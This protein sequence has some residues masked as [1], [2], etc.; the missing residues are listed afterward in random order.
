MIWKRKFRSNKVVRLECLKCLKST[1]N[2]IVILPLRK[3]VNLILLNPR[4]LTEEEIDNFLT[5]IY[6]TL[7][8]SLEKYTMAIHI[9]KEQFYS[10]RR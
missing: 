3:I 8:F 1:W 6:I 7:E 4:L 9:C 10:I 2:Q 5:L